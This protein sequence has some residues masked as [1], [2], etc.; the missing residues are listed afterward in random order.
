MPFC[1]DCGYYTDE[2]IK[3]CPKCGRGKREPTAYS[4]GAAGSYGSATQSQSQ[5]QTQG[6]YEFHGSKKTET[7]YGFQNAGEYKAKAEYNPKSKSTWDYDKRTGAFYEKTAQVFDKA[8]AQGHERLLAACAYL[9]PLVLIPLLLGGKSPFVRF[10][11]NQ[12][13]VNLIAATVVSVGGGVIRGLAALMFFPLS[14]LISAA[15]SIMGACCTVFAILGLIN[16]LNMR[17]KELPLIGSIR[18]LK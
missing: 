18:L 1:S 10:H 9:G 7:E 11:A 12:G 8:G 16:G 5:S 4:G 13:L 2:E 17:Y 3:I 15:L 6:Q 14:G